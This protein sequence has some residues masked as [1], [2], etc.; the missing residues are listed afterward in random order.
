MIKVRGICLA[1]VGLFIVASVCAQS[2]GRQVTR[3]QLAWYS[4]NNTLEFSSKW[5]L[6]TE[7]HE[8]RFRKPDA[9]Q[10]AHASSHLHYALTEK[11]NAS[12]GFSYFLQ[13]PRALTAAERLTIPELRPHI[14][15]DYRQPFR[16]FSIGHR[17]RVEERF[18][19]NTANGELADGYTASYRVRYRLGL[20]YQVAR[21]R[22][23]P[24]KVKLSEEVYVKPASHVSH[25]LFDQN[26]LYVGMNYAVHKHANLEAGYMK[27]FQQRPAQHQFLD[28]EVLSFSVSHRIALKHK[29]KTEPEGEK[30]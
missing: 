22:Q 16:A 19:R 7:L 17:L 18:I 30:M 2:T 15:I 28:R 25:T 9:Q 14:Q 20:E 24:L 1:V 23:L 3:Q 6:T 29:L 11:W 12:A 8:W 10:Q 13:S 4:Y 26:R 27:L 21:L 5:T